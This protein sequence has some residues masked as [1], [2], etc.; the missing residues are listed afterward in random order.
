[1]PAIEVGAAAVFLGML[2]A[3]LIPG[4]RRT[5]AAR[6]SGSVGADEGGN[7]GG[8]EVPLELP[9]LDRWPVAVLPEPANA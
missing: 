3:L 1:M 4:V 5:L 7:G 9:Y 2:S 8:D 6:S